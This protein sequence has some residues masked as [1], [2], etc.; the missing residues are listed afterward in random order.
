MCVWYSL[1][2][3]DEK[4]PTKR[5]RN[6]KS[7]YQ[8]FDVNHHRGNDTHKGVTDWLIQK[9]SPWKLHLNCTLGF[10][11]RTDTAQ[12][13]T[14]CFPLWLPLVRLLRAP[15]HQLLVRNGSKRGRFQEWSRGVREI[16]PH[17]GSLPYH[18]SS[19]H[20]THQLILESFWHSFSAPQKSYCLL[21][22]RSNPRSC[23]W[24]TSKHFL[25][26]SHCTT[27]Q[28]LNETLHTSPE[29]FQMTRNNPKSLI[30]STYHRN[31]VNSTNSL[32]KTHFTCVPLN[33]HTV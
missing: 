17:R 21:D 12:K 9:L 31:T 28:G 32:E 3:G 24:V 14:K 33:I 19:I 7:A 26:C 4:M 22:S 18:M 8:A 27:S 15:S 11:R 20:Q 10:S 29:H 13:A 23:L 2:F 1:L 6:M 30:C 16:S 25:L 5:K